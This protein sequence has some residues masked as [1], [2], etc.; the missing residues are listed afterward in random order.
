MRISISGQAG[1]VKI[2]RYIV[3]GLIGKRLV[4]IAAVH[5]GRQQD[6]SGDMI[7]TLSEILD[8]VELVTIA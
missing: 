8:I 3:F 7:P 1:G 4:A 5:I 2:L 6:Q